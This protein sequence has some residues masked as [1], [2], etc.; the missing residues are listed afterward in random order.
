MKRIMTSLIILVIAL[1]LRSAETGLFTYKVGFFV[2]NGNA[3]KEYRP[4]D[5]PGVWVTYIQYNVKNDNCT[6]AIPKT[7]KNDFYKRVNGEWKVVCNTHVVYP[8]CTDSSV[9]LFC[10]STGFYVRDGKKWRLYLSEKPSAIWAS[11]NQYNDDRFFYFQNNKDKVCVP[12]RTDIN[13]YIWEQDKN[14]WSANWYI[15]EMYDCI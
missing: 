3:W 5:K 8:N 2:K 9:R 12:K 7:S 15:T 14:G 6:L 13:C 10:F 11:F 4:K 1:S